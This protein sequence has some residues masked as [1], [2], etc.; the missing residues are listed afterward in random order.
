MMLVNSKA[1]IKRIPVGT[2]LR[3]IHSL[4]GPCN[5]GK[6]VYEI[7]SNCIVMENTD[8]PKA[9]KLSYLYLDTPGENVVAT[10][11]GF[12]ISGED[13]VTRQNHVRAEYIFEE[14]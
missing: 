12:L 14:I 4:V 9:G 11:K 2:R 13:E 5:M 6:K 8:G 3:L 7:K 1:A 10:S